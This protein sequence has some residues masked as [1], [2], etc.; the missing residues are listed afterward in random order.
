[1]S[2]QPVLTVKLMK[3]QQC[4][5]QFNSTNPRAKYCSG[6]CKVK[7]HRSKSTVTSTVTKP[8]VTS[9]TVTLK[10]CPNNVELLPNCLGCNRLLKVNS[11][12]ICADCFHDKGIT[13]K[14]LGLEC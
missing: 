1:M 14:S 10:P 8:T 4:S 13:H 2:E 11:I 6:A 5:Q 12:C 3:C 7:A 9:E